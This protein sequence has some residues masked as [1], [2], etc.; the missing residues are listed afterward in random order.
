MQIYIGTYTGHEC[1]SLLR[2]YRAPAPYFRAFENSLVFACFRVWVTLGLVACY[3]H[4]LMSGKYKLQLVV[5]SL[6]SEAK[7]F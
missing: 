3:F 7:V 6:E 2:D 5:C 1:G 4:A